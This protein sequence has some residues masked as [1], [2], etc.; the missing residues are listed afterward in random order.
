[1]AQHGTGPQEGQQLQSSPSCKLGYDIQPRGPSPFDPKQQRVWYRISV[2]GLALSAAVHDEFPA[3]R[4]IP[5][6]E[7]WAATIKTTVPKIQET[8]FLSYRDPHRP[9]SRRGGSDDCS[10]HRPGRYR[11]QKRHAADE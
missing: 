11:T 3:Y 7:V 5:A 9:M 1:M 8:K 2:S 10:W 6:F 4:K